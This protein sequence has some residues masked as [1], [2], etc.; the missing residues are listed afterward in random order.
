M[1]KKDKK[2]MD[3]SKYRPFLSSECLAY[4]KLPHELLFKRKRAIN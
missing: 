2:K 3:R 4:Y 1:D